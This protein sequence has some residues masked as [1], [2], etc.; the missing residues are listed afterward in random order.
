MS[1]AQQLRQVFA[2][3]EKT[4]LLLEQLIHTHPLNVPTYAALIAIKIVSSER[5]R[6][7]LDAIY[8]FVGAYMHIVPNAQTKWRN[9]VRHNL[10]VKKC[11]V[12]KMVENR[13]DERA[14]SNLHSKKRLSHS[15]WCLDV[16]NR[17]PKETLRYYNFYLSALSICPTLPPDICLHAVASISFQERL[18]RKLLDEKKKKTTKK[19][20][21]KVT[22]TRRPPQQQPPQQQYQQQHEQ[23]YQQ[24]LAQQRVY[25]QQQYRRQQQP[26][27]V[28]QQP[29]Q[30]QQPQVSQQPPQVSQ[31]YQQQQQQ[32]H[33][34]QVPPMLQQRQNFQDQQN[35]WCCFSSKF[36]HLFSLQDGSNFIPTQHQVQQHS[37]KQQGQ[38]QQQQHQR[39]LCLPTEEDLPVHTHLRMWTPTVSQQ[40]DHLEQP[41]F[42]KYSKRRKERVH[43]SNP[44]TVV[45]SVSSNSSDESAHSPTSTFLDDTASAIV[46]AD[47]L[48]SL[49]TKIPRKV[50]AFQPYTSSNREGKKKGEQGSGQWLSSL[51]IPVP[52]LVTD[53][54]LTPHSSTSSSPLP[55][56]QKENTMGADE[57]LEAKEEEE[58]EERRVDVNKVVTQSEDSPSKKTKETLSTTTI[59]PCPPAVDFFSE[60]E[61]AKLRMKARRELEYKTLQQKINAICWGRRS[62]TANN[63][64]PNSNSNA[65]VHKAQPIV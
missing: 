9:S 55:K 57:P 60:E 39:M 58:K 1:T 32:Q 53:Q 56:H 62:S 20:C 29:Q 46:A 21:S 31:Q 26:P 25:E 10:S 30:Q 43:Q 23:Q 37:Q 49:S 15:Y 38:Q 64:I 28:S 36:K 41:S 45:R 44:P 17:L 3:D 42:R 2:V 13:I 61:Y 24:L 35:Q 4:S 22:P 11:F 19:S 6:Q 16:S 34:P 14:V 12:K 5:Q 27:Q 52:F 59:E 47:I 40:H 54:K 50:T 18:P 51:K 8:P 65:K 63:C 33:P 48:T 7:V